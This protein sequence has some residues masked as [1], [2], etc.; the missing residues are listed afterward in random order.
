M[1]L[2]LLFLCLGLALLVGL[3]CKKEETPAEPPVEIPIS[4]PQQDVTPE[5]APQI[6]V[7][8][9]PLPIFIQKAQSITN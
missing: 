5:P 1:K 3:N 8:P 4:Q 9:I 2:K 7:E 6:L